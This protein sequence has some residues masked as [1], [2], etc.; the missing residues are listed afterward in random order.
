MDLQQLFDPYVITSLFFLIIWI[1]T[2][3][4]REDLQKEMLFTSIIF[5][6]IGPISDYFFYL[7]D[8]W[9]PT[10]TG[11]SLGIILFADAAF[12]FAVGGIS[13][14]IYDV[15]FKQYRKKKKINPKYKRH[16]YLFIIGLGVIFISLYYILLSS[17]IFIPSFTATI[18]TM[19]IGNIIIY[20]F[21]SD[22][23]VESLISGVLITIL[24]II[25]TNIA[26][27]IN[28]TYVKTVWYS[29]STQIII[30]KTPLTDIT[31]WF[32][33]GTL[34]SILY[35]FFFKYKK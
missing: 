7:K 29:T 25:G 35:E 3:I 9:N 16:Y 13:A 23:I 19:L 6:I 20:Y 2:Y 17:G 32:F 12:G 30:L 4:S 34:L 22:I 5:G 26:I 31:W 8:W 28:P 21:R 24:G 15:I 10:F 1:V 18:L 14:I 11:T 27:L 33:T